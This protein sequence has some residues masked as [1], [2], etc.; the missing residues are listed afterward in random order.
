MCPHI[1]VPYRVSL[2]RKH[3]NYTKGIK[4]IVEF[5]LAS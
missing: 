5:C 3:C 1:N 2:E 4:V